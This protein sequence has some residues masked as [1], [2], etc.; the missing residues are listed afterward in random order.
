MVKNDGQVRAEFTNLVTR[1]D[2]TFKIF[3]FLKK[4][5][6]KSYG[7][8]WK[9]LEMFFESFL[10]QQLETL[11]DITDEFNA[12][13][14]TYQVAQTLEGRRENNPFAIHI[15]REGSNVDRVSE[16]ETTLIT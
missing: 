8:L 11:S 13:M 7:K 14:E 3:L 12:M 4:K 15:L 10:S 9:I 16:W 6:S 1:R 2:K 5:K